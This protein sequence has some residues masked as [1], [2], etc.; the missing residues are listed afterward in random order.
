MTLKKQDNDHNKDSDDKT[1]EP[2]GVLEEFKL[3]EYFE[4]LKT[5]KAVRDIQKNIPTDQAFKNFE[6]LIKTAKFRNHEK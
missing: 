5:K 6:D 4:I 3:K 1:N 2:V